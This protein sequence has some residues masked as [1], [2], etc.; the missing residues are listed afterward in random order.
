LKYLQIL[1][2]VLITISQP[3]RAEGQSYRLDQAEIY[4]SAQ[5]LQKLQSSVYKV[6]PTTTETDSL[7][8]NVE[9][10][11]GSDEKNEV[12]SATG[13]L[14]LDRV[15]CP[16]NVLGKTGSVSKFPV[17]YGFS[18]ARFNVDGDPLDV[19]VLGSPKKYELMV[20]SQQF[21]PQKI[22]VIGLVKMEECDKVPCKN[23]QD[24]END[25]K[26][27]GV[28]LEDANYS[29]I[30]NITEIPSKDLEKISV[31]FSNYKGAK[32]GFA[33][34]RV[35]GFANQKTALKFLA[36]FEIYSNGMR[37]KE[38][39]LCRKHYTDLLH[40]FKSLTT[41]SKPAYDKYFLTCQTR[42][43][44]SDFFKDKNTTIQYMRYSA[45]QL[46]H[47]LGKPAMS[48][49]EAIKN[50]SDLKSKG[51]KHYRFVGL[52]TPKNKRVYAAQGSGQLIYEWVKTPNRRKYCS[53][54][55]LPQHYEDNEIIDL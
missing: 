29:K 45:F 54:K 42:V 1:T 17:S 51:K 21:V 31:Y 35:N 55:S 44:S 24:W 30:K 28:D 27:L 25:W 34:T 36:N 53:A 33:Q 18:P 26:I 38:I 5:S 2:L 6:P 48:L 41:K 46:L 40:S 50:M 3:K 4:K 11:Q 37:K 14:I 9:V 20:R 16:K 13:Q 43:F 10:S 19:A 12:R 15:I 8:F 7:Y 52:D 47:K 32:K 49:G 39:D 23:E 22:R